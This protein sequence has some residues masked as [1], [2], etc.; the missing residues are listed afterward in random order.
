MDMHVL[1]TTIRFITAY[2]NFQSGPPA[3]LQLSTWSSECYTRN[4][5]RS[6]GSVCYSRRHLRNSTKNVCSYQQHCY[7]RIESVPPRAPTS[8][9]GIHKDWREICAHTSSISAQNR[10][11]A[12]ES[13]KSNYTVSSLI[14]MQPSDPSQ[15][16]ERVQLV[17]DFMFF[18]KVRLWWYLM[19]DQDRSLPI[20]LRHRN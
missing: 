15:A 17:C 3:W 19:H 7:T 18:K 1:L 9:G 2:L 13:V 20:P 11:C 4:P 8:I 6:I 12:N 5:W 10:Y 14:H 16:T